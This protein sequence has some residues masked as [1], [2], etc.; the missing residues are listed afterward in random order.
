MVNRIKTYFYNYSLKIQTLEW[1]NI[2]INTSYESDKAPWAPSEFR[3]SY[4]LDLSLKSKI[5]VGLT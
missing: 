3:V 4:I 1:Q 2:A 5:W